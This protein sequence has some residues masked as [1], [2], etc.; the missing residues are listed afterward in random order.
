MKNPAGQETQRINTEQLQECQL[1]SLGCV[2]RIRKAERS[3]AHIPPLQHSVA[4]LCEQHCA[5]REIP[6]QT[7]T[8]TLRESLRLSETQFI[9]WQTEDTNIT[10]QDCWEDKRLTN[11][12]ALSVSLHR[13]SL[14]FFYIIIPFL[15]SE[16]GERGHASMPVKQ[17]NEG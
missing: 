13:N 12:K 15:K 4:T 8:L 17:I 11:E 1:P 3:R 5:V 9:Q 6:A 16:Y 7:L 10:S 14:N 2:K